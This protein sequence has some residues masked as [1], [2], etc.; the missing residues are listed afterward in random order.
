[1]RKVWLGMR[2]ENDEFR[3]KSTEGKGFDFL[4]VY[5]LD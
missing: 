3:K 4:G 5:K 2:R 1:M